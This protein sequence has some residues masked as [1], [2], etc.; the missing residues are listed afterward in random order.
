MKRS[1]L[2]LL[3]AFTA[4]GRV[5]DRPA[6]MITPTRQEQPA[7]SPA[8][9]PIQVVAIGDSLAYGAGDE[10]RAGLTGR[11]DEEF[12]S[13]G[14]H[15]GPSVNLGVNGAQTDD[16]LKRM[17]EPRMAATI[18]SANVILL[19]I[20]AND[21]FRS[22]GSREEAF[23]TPLLVASRILERIAQV[24]AEVHRLNPD[25]QVLILGGYNPVPRHPHAKLIDHS[26]GLWDEALVGRFE[27][28]ALVTIV[29]MADLVPASRLSRFDS[30]HPGSVAYREVARRIAAMLAEDS[31]SRPRTGEG[32]K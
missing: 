15:A 23:R 2:A 29:P 9:E 4:C 28:D 21:L 17:K 3:L 18:G 27:D 31:V 5:A 11:L 6:T 16:L 32:G 14:L 26:I 7:S 19:S 22:P 24:V 25:A 8:R 20:G 12:R 10:T 30:F 1:L 13:R